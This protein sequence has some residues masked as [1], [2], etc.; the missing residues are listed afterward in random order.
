MYRSGGGAWSRA[1]GRA[2]AAGEGAPG[3]R[4]PLRLYLV[5]D[6][7][8]AVHRL[9][10]A[11]L[12]R[13]GPAAAADSELRGVDLAVEH[14]LRPA[15]SSGAAAEALPSPVAVT[16]ERALRAGFLIGGAYLIAWLLGL[17]LVEEGDDAR[18]ATRPGSCAA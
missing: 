4:D 13:R 7:A 3:L 5:V 15:G 10:G 9:A 14:L 2:E 1:T 11:V 18:H 12:R 17:D 6:L 8:A 16:L